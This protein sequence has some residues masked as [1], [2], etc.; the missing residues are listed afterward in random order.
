MN[1]ARIHVRDAAGNEVLCQAVDTDGDALLL[2][3]IL[4]FQADFAPNE[5]KTFT[6]E[7]GTRQEYKR[8]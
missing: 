5:T 8:K 3:N 2:P 4:I 6:V 1:L 7:S